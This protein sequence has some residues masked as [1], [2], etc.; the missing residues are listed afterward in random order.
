MTRLA[1]SFA[2]HMLADS[3]PRKNSTPP[4]IDPVE[5]RHALS[6]S[7]TLH[8]V[9]EIRSIGVQRSYGRP[10]A[11]SGYF[12][13]ADDAVKAIL[14]LPKFK[15]IY[16]IMNRFPVDFLAIRA[17]RL[18]VAE[19]NGLTKDCHI[20]RRALLLVDL[21]P[22]R[23]HPD[24]SSTNA[25]HFQA[26]ELASE[27]V[28][29][30]ADE[31][32]W[33]YP[34]M[35]DSGNGF[36]LWY[37]INLPADDGGLVAQVLTAMAARFDTTEVK[38]DTAVSNAARISKLPGS[39]AG[40]GDSL[41]AR[42][43][44]QARPHRIARIVSQVVS[45][46][47]VDIVSTKLLKE[48]ANAYAPPALTPPTPTRSTSK[49]HAIGRISALDR[50]TA[51]LS[52]IPES[53]EGNHGSDRLYQ[54]ACICIKFGLDDAEATQ[55]L[56]TYNATKCQPPWSEPELR[57][58]LNDAAKVVDADGERG[59]MLQIV[60]SAHAQR[61]NDAIRFALEDAHV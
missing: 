50:C 6:L 12:D 45:F 28:G 56:D 53:I 16:W 46:N 30:L 36:G 61:I 20:S 22:V 48:F 59:C 51:Y 8:H 21:D 54:A 38:I 3:A 24:I 49:P 31:F 2:D 10:V 15:A 43:D 47:E 39:M 57:H 18:D 4:H 27:I 40:K 44:I 41:E 11:M 35:F 26:Q 52:K 33:P 19:E 5:L 58:K 7:F 60:E 37:R 55:A 42:P 23:P 34:V 13:N 1:D 29:T 25:E 17:N 32:G 9:I 14:A